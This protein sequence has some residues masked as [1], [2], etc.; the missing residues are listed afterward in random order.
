MAYLYLNQPLFVKLCL[1]NITI[2]HYMD[3]QALVYVVQKDHVI[4]VLKDIENWTRQGPQN[5]I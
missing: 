1:S 3:N 5:L 4:S 2:F